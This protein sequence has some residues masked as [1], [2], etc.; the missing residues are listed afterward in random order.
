MLCLGPQLF[1][2]A[3]VL[4]GLR[5]RLWGWRVSYGFLFLISRSLYGYYVGNIHSGFV[6]SSHSIKVGGG[7]GE[8]VSFVNHGMQFHSN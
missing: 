1:T 5:L 6:V 2:L 8:E 4:L 3:P 7:G